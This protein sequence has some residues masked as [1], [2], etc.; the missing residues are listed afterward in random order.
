MIR[1]RFRRNTDL[2]Q[3]WYPC[4]VCGTD[5]QTIELQ[6]IT[7]STEPSVDDVLAGATSGH[8]GIVV[9][10]D[11]WSGTWA[12]GDAAGLIEL[13][14]PVGLSSQTAD[15]NPFTAFTLSENIDNSTTEDTSVM[16]CHATNYGQGKQYGRFHPENS[17]IRYRGK[18][19]CPWHFNYRFERE[20]REEERLRDVREDNTEWI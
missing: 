16:A 8:G 20:W 9:S 15:S 17:I 3:R 12:G 6:Y 11:L 7:G 14:S 4:V 1:P 13:S 19:Y 2:G 10:V 18:N 5:H